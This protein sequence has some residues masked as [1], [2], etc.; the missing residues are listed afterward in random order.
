MSKEEKF[1]GLFMTAIQQSQGIE[2][3][4]GNLFSCMRRKTDFFKFGDKSKIIVSS[5]LEEQLKI[6]NDD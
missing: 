3:F 4:F 6:Y 2:N 5:A 1:D